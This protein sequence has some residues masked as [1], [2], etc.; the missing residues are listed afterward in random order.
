M[1]LISTQEAADWKRTSPQN[2][3]LAI[4]RGEID[5]VKVGKVYLV[6]ANRKFE[7][8]QLSKRHVKAARTR[9][10]K[11]KAIEKAGGS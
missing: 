10:R 7:R 3:R 4:R 8:W 5:S 11:Q 9:W 2:I 6:K 1:N